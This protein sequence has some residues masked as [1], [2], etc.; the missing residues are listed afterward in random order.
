MSSW[1][2]FLG[3]A[4][5]GSGGHLALNPVDASV[6]RHVLEDAVLQMAA[7]ASPQ[8]TLPSRFLPAQM[9]KHKQKLAFTFHKNACFTR[10]TFGNDINCLLHHQ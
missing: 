7:F 5:A 2:G 10:M 8:E 6:L 4:G 9:N 1:E 3:E